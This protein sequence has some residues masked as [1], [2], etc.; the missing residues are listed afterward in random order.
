MKCPYC[1]LEMEQGLI[2]SNQELSWIPG[3]RRKFFG[4]AEFH[5]DS[6]VLSSF[7]FLRGSAVT[8]YLCRSCGKIVIDCGDEASDLNAPEQG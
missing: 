6:V 5:K 7:S 1:G 8:A 4:R 3:S 2:Q